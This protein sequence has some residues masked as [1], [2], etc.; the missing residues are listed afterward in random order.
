MTDR[1]NEFENYIDA[2]YGS[3]ASFARKVGEV[4]DIISKLVRLEICKRELSGEHL[5]N[6]IYDATGGEITPNMFFG[7]D[8]FP[9]V[10]S[11]D[12]LQ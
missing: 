11:R 9:S 3:Q 1:L 6:K 2:E 7:I 10:R 5:F 12:D 8:E 4:R